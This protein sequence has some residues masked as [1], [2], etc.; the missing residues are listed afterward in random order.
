MSITTDRIAKTNGIGRTPGSPDAAA[1][2]YLFDAVK[3]TLDCLITGVIVV[4]DQGRI[5]HSNL[6]AQEMLEAKSPI[7]QHGGCL[8]ALQAERTKELR[9]AIVTAQADGAAIGPAGLSVALVDKIGGHATAHIL[10][11]TPL[12]RT[13]R[14]NAHMPVVVFILSST[15]A[16]PIEIGAVVKSFHLTPAEA[17]LLQ[18]LV[19]GASLHEAAAALGIAEPTARTHR[20]HI[21]TKTGVSRRNDLLLLISRLVPPIRR[22]H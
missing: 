5:L 18:Q 4:G 14:R 17:R 16:L 2:T 20:N 19:S 6:A 21:F 7:I 11:L 10:P 1:S 13:G 15:I 9:R 22:P 12:P 3:R 8:C